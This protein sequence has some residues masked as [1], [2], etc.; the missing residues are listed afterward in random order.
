MPSSSTTS[1]GKLNEFTKSV[2]G[3]LIKKHIDIVFISPMFI[4]EFANSANLSLTFYNW[5][6]QC[7]ELLDRSDELW[8]LKFDGWDKSH[9]VRHELAYA[10]DHY[11][12]RKIKYIDIHTI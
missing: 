8:I 9:G 1:D 7:Y 4:F 5:K 11:N 3:K 10:N 2:I 6:E 12:H